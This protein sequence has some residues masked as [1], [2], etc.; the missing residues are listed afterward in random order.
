MMMK[1]SENFTLDHSNTQPRGSA[2]DLLV[3]IPLVLKYWYWFVISVAIALFVSNWYVKHTMAVYRTTATILVNDREERALVDNSDLL[4]GLGLPG[5]MK[6]IQNQ[7]MLLKSR[8]LTERTLNELSYEVE[9]YFR[10]IRNRLPIYP[11]MPVRVI[12]ETDNPL[13]K[14]IEFSLEFIN[15]STFILESKSKHFPY[16]K[17]A[18]FGENIELKNGSFSIEYR[19]KEWLAR[20][21]ERTLYFKIHSRNR[22][23]NSYGNRLKVELVS[24]EGSVLRT[25]LEGTNRAKDVDFLNKHIQGFQAISLDK[26]NA[27]AIRRIQFI[28]DQLVGISDSLSLTENKLQQ[29]RS[30]HRVMDLSAQGQSIIGQVTLLENEKARL[31]LEANYYDYLADY[32]E[33]DATG[34]VPIVPVTMGITDPGLTRLVTELTE[35]QGQ[36]TARGAG[37]MNPL[38]RNLGIRIRS[39]KD[40]LKETLNGLRRAN[41]LARSENQQQI[42]RANAQASALPVTERQLLGIERKFELNNELYTY[43]LETRAEQEM[44]KASNRADSEVIDPADER[45][46]I[47]VSPKKAMVT[48]IALFLGFAIPLFII[49]VKNLFN[50]NLKYDDIRRITDLPIVGNLPRY[51]GKSN[52]VVFDDPSSSIANPSGC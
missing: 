47:L 45:F 15:D 44:Q 25:S 32:L 39:A 21:M 20:N 33:K 11:E 24:R 8:A 28:D 41:S 10:T 30:S 23:T 18:V 13:P 26:K 7:I 40:A 22:L 36:L 29:F 1:E 38:Q 9:F 43:L 51:Q 49:I 42:N 46:S 5:G 6:N 12:P 3:I 50:K 31:S 17:E 37:E 4:Q 2:F 48:L 52:T 35:L 27:E 34:E 16:R 14:D 19:D